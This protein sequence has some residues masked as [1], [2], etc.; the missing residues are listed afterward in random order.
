MAGRL[1]VGLLGPL[2]VRV[3]GQVVSVPRGKQRTL[4]AILLLRA[5]RIVTADQ[6]ADLIWADVPP[7]SATV[8]LQNHVKR[9]RQALGSVG[10]DRIRTQPGGYLIQ[11][12]S[13]ELDL[14]VM[15]QALSDAR[16]AGREADWPRT[17]QRAAA[18]LGVWRG[19]PLC[20]IDLSP[21]AMPEIARLTELH[22]QALELRI[23][24]DL[25]LT[26]HADVV[27]ELGQL[28]A[29]MPLREHLHAMLM[30]ALYRCGRRAEALAA[31]RG[32]RDVLIDELGAEPG[33]AIQALHQ[34]ILSDDPALS[35]PLPSSQL[36]TETQGGA[37]PR[38]LPATVGCFTGR[39]AELAALTGLLGPQPGVR[40]Q[41]LVI[42]AIG[43]TAGVGKTALAVQWA[44]QAADWFPDGQLYVNLRGY[45]PH[46]PVHASD[47][48]A[49]FLR[50]L[51]LPGP[52]I[53]DD[54]AERSALY[55]SHLAGRRM[56]VLLDNA[57]DGEHV[58]PLL[59][60]EQGCVAVVTSRDALAGLVA[61]D[62]A[63]RIQL[64]VLPLPDA[65]ALLRSLIGGRVDDDPGAAA[66]LAE[67]CASLPLA[68]RI[69]AEIA[70][71]RPAV[72]LAE[73]VSELAPARLDTLDAGEE[74]ADVRAVI[75]WSVRQLPDDAARSFALI[76]LH[77]GEDLDKHA[78]AA[79]TST[80][81]AGAKR[82]FGRLNRA[83]LLQTTAPGRY[84]MH[85]LLRAYAREQAA[86]RDVSGQSQQA[87]TQLFDYYLAAAAR[88]MDTLFPAE[89]HLRPQVAESAV[90]LP[91][92]AAAADARAWLDSERA[93]LVTVV[94]DCAA[95]G[96]PEYVTRLAATLF[97]YLTSGGHLQD[98]QVIY[99]QALWSAR[100]SGDLA[101]E[102][103]SLNGLGGIGIMQGNFRAAAAQYLAALECYRLCGDR[104]GQAKVLNNLGITADRMS[105]RSTAANYY[106]Q[107]MA[108]YEDAG[109]RHG[110]ARAQSDLAGDEA[111]LGNLDLAYEHLQVALRTFRETH[112]QIREAEALSRIG[113]L[114]LMRDQLAQAADFFGQAL[115]IF[116]LIDH[117]TGIATALR[118]LGEVGLRLGEYQQASDS[119]RQA[120]SQYRHIGHQ[121]GEMMTLRR[122]AEA[123]HATG[124][125]DAARADLTA[126][127]R[128]A[129]ETGNVYE[130]ANVHTDIGETCRAAGQHEQARHHWEQAVSLYS[131]LGAPEADQVRSQLSGLEGRSAAGWTRG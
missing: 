65:L 105:D 45:D 92:M 70:V 26:R 27:T 19:E 83:S 102:G 103:A 111:E 37:V 81:I 66:E 8:T 101:A 120:L 112:D 110:V 59:P 118:L 13:G 67:L 108:A 31:Y 86:A 41:A 64:D 20:D 125:P 113:E 3:D 131:E 100:G 69:A 36:A 42:S 91:A 44:H 96:K 126:A 21:S 5:G 33:P 68:L 38:Q 17:A 61:S 39:D 104:A 72:P 53:P 127:L 84:G 63:R 50:A 46:Q 82:T 30:L 115:A 88:A 18:A 74:R 109:D 58:R 11:V 25:Q 93:N 7:P 32:A 130:Q 79:M 95:H 97:R 10:R 29:A 129:S 116:R 107:A 15:E 90:V 49:G 55:R 57:R 48:L 119:L 121:Y 47:A 12:E 2:L 114:S 117:R 85:D 71:A 1:D 16:Q 89:A 87:L 28:V 22:L 98:A 62:G 51:G 43:G 76:G 14:T 56:L 122:L 23:E 34:Q 52:E 73:L 124:K 24:A 4:L 123:R 40:A 78:C 77:P 106:R 75:S 9:L 60:G 99:G 54:L 80:S 128:L 6:L 94:A 35:P